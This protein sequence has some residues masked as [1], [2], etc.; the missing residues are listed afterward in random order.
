MKYNCLK[1]VELLYYCPKEAEAEAELMINIEQV[2]VTS[3][4]WSEIH[5]L[6]THLLKLGA[7]WQLLSRIS[8]QGPIKG[9]PILDLVSA[10]TGLFHVKSENEHTPYLHC[11]PI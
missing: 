2:T 9:L 11:I 7:M 3:H 5:Y 10:H 1:L 6:R 8:P 4:R